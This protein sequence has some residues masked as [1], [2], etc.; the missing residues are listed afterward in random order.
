MFLGKSCC[1]F[2]QSG[3]IEIELLTLVLYILIFVKSTTCLKIVLCFHSHT[4]TTFRQKNEIFILKRKAL[5]CVKQN[6][7]NKQ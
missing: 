1:L 3:L 4:I 2:F 7:L 6:L 5:R